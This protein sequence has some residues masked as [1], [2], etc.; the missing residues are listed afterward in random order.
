MRSRRSS[1]SV[2]ASC[3]TTPCLRDGVLRVEVAVSDDKELAGV[4]VALDPTAARARSR[5]PAPARSVAD[6]SPGTGCSTPSARRGA[7]VVARDGARNEMARPRRW[8]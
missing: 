6:L 4:E 1:S 2:V 5:L 3:S 7:S 8:R